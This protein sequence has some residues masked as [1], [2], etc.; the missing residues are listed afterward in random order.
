MLKFSFPA[1]LNL[2]P[3]HIS[4]KR[5]RSAS[6]LIWYLENYYRLDTQAAVDSVCDF[7]GDK[8]VDGIFVNDNDQTITIFQATII[9]S[10]TKAIGDKTLRE[11]DGT[12]NQFRDA[13]TIQ[14]FLDSKPND[15]LG[16]LIKRLDLINKIATYALQGEFLC[17]VDQD[18]NA[19]GVLTTSPHLSFVGET[20]LRDTYI[21]YERDTPVHTPASFDIVGRDVTKYMG[22]TETK[23]II[24]AVKAI[25]LVALSE[26]PEIMAK[27]IVTKS[28]LTAR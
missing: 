1:I 17:N 20:V 6:F 7:R 16:N 23:V 3:Q 27:K 12:I 5:S 11:F 8:G 26:L 13:T 21:S 9:E 25:E 10:T 2:F 24:A 14:L 22:D 18:A 4:P 28:S 19:D 15:K